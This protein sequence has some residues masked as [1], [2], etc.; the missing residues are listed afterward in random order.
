MN[1]FNIIAIIMAGTFSACLI[2]AITVW[3]IVAL[4]STKEYNDAGR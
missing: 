4:R 2:T 1:T 3:A